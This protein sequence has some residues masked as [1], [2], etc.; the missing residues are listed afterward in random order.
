MW[1]CSWPSQIY[2]ETE[3]MF[4][5]E[6]LIT[7][8]SLT[9]RLALHCLLY[10]IAS[11]CGNTTRFVS[12][13]LELISSLDASNPW[14]LSMRLS[15]VWNPKLFSQNAKNKQT[16]TNRQ[17]DTTDGRTDGQ[18]DRQTDTDIQTDRQTERRQ[19]DRRTDEW[20]DGQTDRQADKP[21]LNFGENTRF[22]LLHLLL[23]WR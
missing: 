18:T 9:F 5:A 4:L 14:T 23:W 1:E 15:Q 8:L 3:E 7:T 16:Q 11:R 13:L 12:T 19:K 6:F 10:H 2:P 17:A 20:T 22:T 21:K